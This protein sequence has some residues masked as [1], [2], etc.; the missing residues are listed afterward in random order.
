MKQFFST[1]VFLVIALPFV[2]MAYDVFR[3]IFTQ[4]KKFYSKKAK[5]VLQGMIQSIVNAF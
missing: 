1:L 4:L 3:D 2:Y 5:P